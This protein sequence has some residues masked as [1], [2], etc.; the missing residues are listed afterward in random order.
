MRTVV[1]PSTRIVVVGA[2]LSGLC[3]ALHLLGAGRQV[4]VLERD[5]APGGRM[6]VLDGPGYRA[7]SGATVLT[8]PELIDDALAAVGMTRADASPPL[9]LTRLTP[10]YRARFTD[11]TVFDVHSDP[12]AMTEE[13][14]RVFGAAE[15]E[16]YL[17]LRAWLERMFT[18]EFDRFLDSSFDSPL[19]LVGSPGALADL[20]RVTALGGFGR[21]GPRVARH[22]R[23]PRLRR[24]FTF[25]SLY[26]GLA[27]RQALAVYGAI[28]HMDTSLGVYFPQGGMHAVSRTLADAVIR[29]GGAIEYCAQAR[30]VDIADGRAHAVLTSDGR[31]H[32]CD[33]LVMTPD[34]P[35]TD[36]LLASAGA[37]R[38][39][40][41]AG[42]RFR[43]TRWSPSA[44]VLHGTIPRG[45]A[46]PVADAWDRPHHHT[47][48]FGGAWEETFA[49]ICARPGRGSLMADPSF[50]LTR[51]GLTDPGLDA[52]TAAGPREL[53]SVLAPC[54]NLHS[55]PLPWD[56][57]GPSYAGD[58]LAVL[59]RR[60]YTGISD[61]ARGLRVDH[62]FTPA[63]WA[64][65]GMGAG[66][67]FSAAHTFRQTGPFRRPNLVR[68]LENTVLAGCG[69]NPGVGVPTALISGRLAAE[70][71]IGGS[72]RRRMHP[73]GAEDRSGNVSR[74]RP[75][76]PDPAPG[77]T[78]GA[79]Q[80]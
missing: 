16:G 54:P 10:A 51:P 62:V 20:A 46:G 79:D 23:D 40:A 38:H 30:S 8:M 27:P 11:G 44:V 3:A 22:I 52:E 36:A 29:A 31:I 32:D 34:L 26:A 68:G 9:R 39:H 55:A 67:P 75:S 13:V 69:T 17:R 7:D 28:P 78:Q 41:L 65:Q 50:L 21:L 18:A 47:I 74:S 56:E 42:G 35:V 4:T 19:D 61:P 72:S 49:Q 70:R 57:L 59:E 64:A 66:S 77:G 33:A 73:E 80:R 45:T 14:A 63:T 2:G 60:G 12:E 6:G 1:G 15:A 25:Q 71:I 43:R 48:D 24:V 76:A 58:I 53:M 37:P 5:A